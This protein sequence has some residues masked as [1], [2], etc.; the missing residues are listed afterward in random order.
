[1][2]QPGK[3]KINSLL[4]IS[5]EGRKQIDLTVI[6]QDLNIFES[7]M[8]NC[9]TG[10]VTVT[11]TYN[12]I[13][14]KNYALPI[15]GNE[16]IYIEAELPAYYIMN[17]K[18]EWV[19]GSPNIIKYY[20]RVTD[21]KNLLLIN[22]GAQN[23]EIHF[24]SEE[25]ILSE[26]LKLSQSFKEKPISE[27]VTNVFNGNFKNTVS[28]YEFEKTI[29]NHTVVF[30]NWSPLKTINWLASRAISAAYKTAQFFFY[31]SLYNDGGISDP[32]NNFGKNNTISSTKYWFISLDEMIAMWAGTVR[33]TIFYV[34]A[35]NNSNYKPTDPESYMKFSNALNYEVANSFN[36]L[37]NA[38]SGLFAS[39]M[40]TH[41]I[42][43]KTYKETN[44]TYDGEYNKYQHIDVAPLFT[45]V[46]NSQ[47]KLFTSPDYCS[48]HTMMSSK[49][50]YELPNYLDQISYTRINRIQSLGSY[51]LNLL[52]PGDGLIEPGDIIDFKMTSPEVGG[53][54]VVYDE[55]YNGKYL[56]SAIRHVFR[57]SE[58][59][60]SLECSKE[61]LNQDVRRY[62]SHA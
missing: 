46:K 27:I 14:G 51:T 17:D 56:V 43:N 28:S 35:N 62:P 40:I 31:Q 13:S 2:I 16:I 32:T 34:P 50:T 44:Y 38:S 26:S 29:N 4:I 20:G 8:T 49:G 19:P 9:I 23:Y 15:M 33:K 37:A 12:L 22:D 42:T 11:D 5:T 36:T 54:G 25:M 47:G 61:S 21:I 24:C 30:P 57:R 45:G 39:Q 6:Y 7:I 10:Y 3:Y 41:D 53:N 55:F 58:Y 48:T 60:M 59:K 18:D 52:I 1:M